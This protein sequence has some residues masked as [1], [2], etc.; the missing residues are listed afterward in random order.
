MTRHNSI[1][2]ALGVGPYQGKYHLKVRFEGAQW[3][4]KAL[5]GTAVTESHQTEFPIFDFTVETW[6]PF[7]KWLEVTHPADIDRMLGPTVQ[8]DVEFM[9]V[10][11]ERSPLLSD[12]SSVLL[13]ERTAEFVAMHSSN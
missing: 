12:E 2:R 13:R 1:S 4:G 9:I 8:T 5:G 10:A 7:V 3:L 11:G 6:R